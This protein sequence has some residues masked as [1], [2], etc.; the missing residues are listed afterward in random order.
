M[1]TALPTVGALIGREAEVSTLQAM[2]GQGVRLLTLTGPPGVG[3]TRLAIEVARWAASRL[4]DGV[5]FVDL[6]SC[7]DGPGALEELAQSLGLDS[8]GGTDRSVRLRSW[9][10]QREL[11]LVLDTAEQVAGLALELPDILGSSPRLSILVTS[12]ENLHLVQEHEFS[13]PPLAMPRPDDVADVARIEAV[14]AVALFM[15]RARAVRPDFAVN[16]TNVDAVAEICVRLDGLPLALT[17]AA[18]RVKMFAP[19]EIAARIRDRKAILEATAKDVPVRHRSLH[20]AISWSHAV[21]SQPE[22]RLFRRLSVFAA[23][24][25]L[26]A[27]EQ[28]CGDDD[29]DVAMTLTSLVDKSLVQSWLDGDE[30][31]FSM[32]QSIREFAV[33]EYE[34]YDGPETRLAHAAY[35]VDRSV[36][37]EGALG[38]ADESR[39]C[40]WAEVHRAD[41]AAARR[42][43]RDDG[44]PSAEG[45]LTAALGWAAYT[46][47]R[48]GSGISVVDQTLADERESDSPSASLVAVRLIG[49]VLSWAAGELDRAEELLGST[50]EHCEAGGDTRRTAMALAFLGH[51]ARERCDFPTAGDC[52]ERASAIFDELAL[53]RGA[54]W[55]RFDLGRVAWERGDLDV[56]KSL[57][58]EALDRSRQA[59]Y[60]WATA[61]ASWA[62]G[63]VAVELAEITDGSDLLAAALTEFERASDLRGVALCWE[64]LAAVAL[65][66]SRPTESVTLVSAASAVRERLVAPRTGI[67]KSR[68]EEVVRVA[69]TEL[70][71]HRFGM[72]T[73]DGHTMPAASVYRLAF[74]VAAAPGLPGPRS[75][76]DVPPGWAVLTAREREVATLVAHGCTNQQIGRRLGI[77]TRTAEAHVSNIMTKLHARSRAEI[78][79]WAVTRTPARPSAT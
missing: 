60:G 26:E 23:P 14:P 2:L 35:F 49:G 55:A 27:A 47:G 74:E 44:D 71:D 56:A 12:R 4:T 7:H 18:P 29:V 5:A 20:A 75:P 37:C 67:T 16:A 53:D 40:D 43:A 15:A 21:L 46:H 38:S 41:L 22:R 52:H 50:L 24:W 63:S 8:R 17:L 48:V 36:G 72:A 33:E 31:R 59:G 51:V 6:S 61:W 77:A 30:A 42:V 39:W 3:K 32:L 65:A 69:R 73:S 45:A 54:A 70:G 58:S 57:L 19:A 79:V 13:V 1:N 78:A 9:L 10:T 66:T 64:S 62:L 76:I 11:L 34:R 25:T 28:I 68:A